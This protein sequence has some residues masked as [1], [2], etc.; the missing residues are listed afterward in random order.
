MKP[1][2]R[3]VTVGITEPHPLSTTVIERAAAHARQAES[4]YRAEGYEV[5]TIRLSSR[6]L[7]GDLLSST[8]GEILDY[9][10][11]LQ[12]F[13]EDADIVWMSVGPAPAHRP[14]FSLERLD[15]EADLLIGA[16]AL[17]CS[18]QIATSEDGIRLAAAERCARIIKRLAE[19][20]DEG[21]GNFRFAMLACVPPG[22]PFFPAAYHEGPPSLSIGWQ[23]AG[24]V[25][26]AAKGADP[27]S[28]TE[29]VRQAL[30]AAGTPIV[31]IGERIAQDLGIRFGGIDVSPAPAGEDSIGA[32]IEQSGYGSFGAPGTLAVVEAL[33]AA[34]SSTGLPTCGYN[35]LMLPVMED[36]VIASRWAEGRMNIHQLLAYSAVCGTGLDAVPLPGDM[37]AEEIGALLL[38]VASLA[39]RLRKPLSARLL[40]VPGSHRG[41]WTTFSSP[42]LVNTRI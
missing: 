34:L 12:R 17:N 42:Y 13:L 24:V 30:I 31:N 35:G 15:V 2:I 37:A 1:P 39:V 22:S 27:E 25:A 29:R 32:A 9:A 21:F 4:A 18:V 19:E 7:M 38:D 3:A 36:S 10:S 6:P 11:D 26:A 33:T 8:P 28:L 20:T 14:D 23:G 16:P 40:P 5:Q 41:D